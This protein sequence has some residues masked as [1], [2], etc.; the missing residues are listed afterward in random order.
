MRGKI[1]EG[2]FIKGVAIFGVILIHVTAYSLRTT[3]PLTE[4][5]LFYANE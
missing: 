1:E 2:D 4:G 3:Q 5:G